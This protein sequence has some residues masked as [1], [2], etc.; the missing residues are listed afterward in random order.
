M[1]AVITG[2]IINSRDSNPDVWMLELKAVLNK[3]GQEPKDWEIFRGDSFQL[4][5]APQEAL[6]A[7]I[8]FKSYIKQIKS[9]DVRMGIGI[10]DIVYQ[11]E[12]IT[13]ANGPAFIHSGESFE[14][15]KKETLKI[16]SQ[17]KELDSSINLMIELASLTIDNWT[18]TTSKIIQTALENPNTKQNEIA[19]ILNK[20][21]ST[22]SEALKRGG[23]DEIQKMIAFFQQEINQKC[24]NLL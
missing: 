3:Y 2:D 8:L 13:A 20:S 9:I 22:I 11:S 4:M 23:Y 6:E 7:A 10:G 18:P 15:L 1:I 24:L 12:K 14:S 5:L 19:R 21:Q 17:W 16:K